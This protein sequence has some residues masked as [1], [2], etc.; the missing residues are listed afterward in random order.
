MAAGGQ[1]K[2]E[3]S[4]LLRQHIP[5]GQVFSNCYHATKDAKN[6]GSDGYHSGM[7]GQGQ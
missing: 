1:E 3:D 6:L 5:L 7:L 2:K 4:S